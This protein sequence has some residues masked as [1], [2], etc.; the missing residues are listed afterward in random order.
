MR[1]EPFD[2]EG[3]SSGIESRAEIGERG[4]EARSL[5][6]VN[7]IG[8][9]E[10]T[11]ADPQRCTLRGGESR[12]GKL[13]E[14]PHHRGDDLGEE[15]IGIVGCRVDLGDIAASAE[16]SPFPAQEK[17]SNSGLLCRIERCR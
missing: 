17:S 9:D 5:T 16:C 2:E 12:G 8:G 14:P 4:S 13:G 15:R 3:V 11:Q 6:D 10:E 7:H 1:P